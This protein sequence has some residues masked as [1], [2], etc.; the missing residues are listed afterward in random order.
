MTNLYSWVGKRPVVAE[1]WR[2][3][4]HVGSK[5]A[6]LEG[7]TFPGALE[8]GVIMLITTCEQI[9]IQ[10]L[11]HWSCFCQLCDLSGTQTLQSLK[12]AVS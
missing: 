9:Y 6:W 10:S 12:A 4:G 11:I 2:W 7:T 8:N 5:N 1:M 3:N